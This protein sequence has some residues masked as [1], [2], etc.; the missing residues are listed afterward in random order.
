MERKKAACREFRQA[1]GMLLFKSLN[2][3][4]IGAIGKFYTIAGYKSIVRKITLACAIR[5]IQ[6]YKRIFIQRL[7]NHISVIS[8]KID[9][10]FQYYF[11]K[12]FCSLTRI[13]P[14]VH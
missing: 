7:Q 12:Y 1:V 8:I 10:R 4:Y 6:C 3:I 9:N 2:Q 5:A 14:I 11:G 13:D